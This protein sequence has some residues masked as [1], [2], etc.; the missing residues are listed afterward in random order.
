MGLTGI[1]NVYNPC[2][3]LSFEEVVKILDFTN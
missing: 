2:P 3:I 1:I